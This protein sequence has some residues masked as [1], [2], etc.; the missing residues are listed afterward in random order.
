MFN[1]NNCKCILESI[2]GNIMIINRELKIQYVNEKALKTLGCNETINGK[3]INEVLNIFNAFSK[4][5]VHI[6]YTSIIEENI[7][8]GLPQYSAIETESG[9]KYLSASIAPYKDS[10]ENTVGIVILFRDITRFMLRER[11]FQEYSVA[12]EETPIGIIITDEEYKIEYINPKGIEIGNFPENI[13]GTNFFD[14]YRNKKNQIIIQE[15][16]QELKKCGSVSD[17]IL[18]D[19]EANEE[20]WYHLEI[21]KM[22]FLGQIKNIVILNDISEKRSVDKKLRKEKKLLNKMFKEL[23]IG[24]VLLDK[25]LNFKMNNEYVNEH[26]NLKSLSGVLDSVIKTDDKSEHNLKENILASRSY[27][28]HEKKEY[29]LTINNRTYYT[30]I[31]IIKFYRNGSLNYLLSIVDYTKKKIIQ[32]RLNKS[33]GNLSIITKN[34]L[35]TITLINLSGDIIYASPSHKALFGYTPDE[36]LGHNVRNFL[37]DKNSFNITRRYNQLKRGKGGLD[38]FLVNKKDG[39][40]IWIEAKF[41]ITNYHGAETITIVSRDV[42]DKVIARNKLIK[43]KKLAEKND[44][45]KGE[46][47]ANTSHEIR[48]PLNGIIGMSTIC[49][50]EELPSKVESNVKL[51]KSSAESL[52]KI[53]NGILDFSKIEAG[54]LEII[55]NQ[56]DLREL[57]D[58][59]YKNFL[60]R[61]KDKELDIIVD[62]SLEND[63]YIGDAVRI[64]QILI[65]LV[66]NAIK[67]TSKGYVKIT[68]S[69]MRSSKELAYIKFAVKDTGIGI[70]S[71]DKNN[72][73]KSFSQG[74]GSFTRRYGG[75]GLGLSI[76]KMLVEKMNGKIDFDSKKGQ[77]S[78]FR[79]VL[80]LKPTAAYEGDY[81]HKEVIAIGES[82]NI[83]LVEDEMTN[84]KFMKRL[85]ERLG[86]IVDVAK[87]GVSA[88]DHVMHKK[89]DMVLMD[90]QLPEMDGIKATQIIKNEL[91]INHMP[92]I[93]VTAHARA[94]DKEKILSEGLDDYISK[95]ISM[96]KLKKVIERHRVEDRNISERIVDDVFKS[97]EN[98]NLGDEIDFVAILELIENRNHKMLENKLND[99]K[100]YFSQTDEKAKRN[101]IFKSVMAL[102]RRDYELVKRYIKEIS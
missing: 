39:D 102:R 87:T 30:E 88:I 4:E 45:M 68:I 20:T 35:D 9:E 86:H 24:I 82:L 70:S 81:T 11:V 59:V 26:F 47:L 78:E 46:F 28:K 89:F 75:T 100:E 14:F 96:E 29:V 19:I 42:N 74:D 93:A 60:Y 22:E 41:S 85:L 90:I 50:M 32:D 80:P 92:I 34:M 3:N 62:Y 43:A 16:M 83:L 97:N 40:T 63:F 7:S 84:A 31:G 36:I 44:K 53:I 49:L 48:T 66:G 38:E 64:K 99:L 2:D 27:N 17:D 18:I 23:P 52:M 25:D 54:K 5:S 72:V 56:F 65:N 37:Y 12:L 8:T 94:E 79:F 10:N 6:N 1:M 69:K 95:P 76:C 15:V 61:S 71:Y 51:I 57:I 77:G 98:I 33:E 101:I 58:T 55:T 73:F 13:Y 67:F 91:L 21:G